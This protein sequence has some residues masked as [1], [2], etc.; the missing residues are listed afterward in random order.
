[1]DP[2]DCTE[3]LLGGCSPLSALTPG[4][5]VK[6][7]LSPH[8]SVWWWNCW[9]HLEGALSICQ[10]E[11]IQNQKDSYKQL[12]FLNLLAYCVQHFKALS[13]RI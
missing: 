8:C 13:V 4:E 2:T 7:C 12:A 11:E 10:R 6:P 1:M 5:R 3:K 9:G